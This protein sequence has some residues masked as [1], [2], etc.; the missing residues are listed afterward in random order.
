MAGDV[1]G[2]LAAALGQF[3]ANLVFG[4]P[5]GGANLDMVGAIEAAG[6]RF[7]LTHGETAATIM[8][9]VTAE[10]TGHP[11]AVV[12]TRGPGVASAINGTAQALLDRQ[13]VVVMTECVMRADRDRISHQRLDHAALMNAVT[14]ASIRLGRQNTE[15]VAMA[16]IS[17]SLA[18]RP[19]PVHLDVD[20]SDESDATS[21]PIISVEKTDRGAIGSVRAALHAARRPVVIAGMGALAATG[22]LRR[23]AESAGVPVLTT[24]K[25]RG[26]VADRSEVAAGVATGAAIESPLLSRADLIL[27]V[28]LDTVEMIPAPWPYEAPVV[29]IGRWAVDDSAYFGPQLRAE[30]V[31][32]ISD[33]LNHLTSDIKADWDASEGAFQRERARRRLLAAVPP[34]PTAMLPQ[35]VITR[36]RRNCPSGTI[37]TVDAGAH[38]LAAVPL[39][40]VDAPGQLIISSGLAT[41]GFALPAAIAAALVRPERHVLCFT[42]DGG[43]GMA[44]A[45]L[46]TLVRLCLPVVVVVFND[47]TLSLIA[48]KQRAEGQGDAAAV[49]YA[50]IDYAGVGAACGLATTQVR[51]GDHYERSL[52]QALDRDGPTLIDVI[53]DPSGYAAIL[54]TIRG[55]Q[56]AGWNVS[57]A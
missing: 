41:M 49:R 24:Y 36:A 6:G 3:E 42:G 18:G 5:G 45:E 43:L 46:E 9:G 50:P 15:A 11:G 35:E 28:G 20:P 34:S 22:A 38:M 16:A 48:A 19:G 27:G 52:R 55:P 1:I 17:L 39:W 8:A 56:P 32:N 37:A 31:G 57:L 44:L 54:E 33:L 2:H 47:S 13:P 26:L 7:V 10:L 21:S 51:N 25:G 53:V 4:V 14:K 29:L 30:L 23:F 12:V 40:E